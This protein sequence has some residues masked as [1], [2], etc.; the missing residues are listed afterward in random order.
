MGIFL[1]YH[2]HQLA[3]GVPHTSI[4]SF[5]NG[6]VKISHVTLVTRGQP[7]QLRPCMVQT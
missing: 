2:N 1:Q 5:F 3:E 4:K 7:W 6:F